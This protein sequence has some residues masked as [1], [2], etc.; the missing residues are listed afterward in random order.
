MISVCVCHAFR[1]AEA[2]L[3]QYLVAAIFSTCKLVTRIK[4]RL[5]VL[6][7][8]FDYHFV[9]HYIIGLMNFQLKRTKENKTNT[10]HN[11]RRHNILITKSENHQ[12]NCAVEKKWEF[13][14][15][16]VRFGSTVCPFRATS[17]NRLSCVCMQISNVNKLHLTKIYSWNRR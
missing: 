16:S 10:Y 14:Y 4:E 3:C 9:C 1:M 7:R 11:S 5:S 12:W 6:E 17:D 8:T 2:V 15:Y 13:I